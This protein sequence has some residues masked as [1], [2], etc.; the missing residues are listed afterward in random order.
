MHIGR[1]NF[2]AGGRGVESKEFAAVTLFFDDAKAM[3]HSKPLPPDFKNGLL[4]RICQE[5]GP[6]QTPDS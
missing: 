5:M 3:R 2:L 4:V 6:E 1:I